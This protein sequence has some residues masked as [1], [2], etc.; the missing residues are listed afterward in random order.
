MFLKAICPL[1]YL[2]PSLRRVVPDSPTSPHPLPPLIVPILLTARDITTKY[3]VD[4]P[5]IIQAGEGDGQLEDAIMSFSWAHEKRD[6]AKDGGDDD[7]WTK[8]WL[9]RLERRE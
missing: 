4:L 3:R 2:V 6:D 9:Q 8:R 5:R 7:K 1:Y